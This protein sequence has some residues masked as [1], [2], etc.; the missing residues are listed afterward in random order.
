MTDELD[1]FVEDLQDQIY[2]E[3]REAFGDVVYNRW[4]NP[5]HMGRMDL[6]DGHARVSGSCG[7]TMEIFLRFKDNRVI[8]ASFLTDGCGPSL[9]CASYAAELAMGKSP[10]EVA[11]VSGW[12]I[13]DLL[14]G[15]PEENEHCAFLAAETLH[16]ALSNYTD[17]PR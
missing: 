16:Q 17:R 3:T 12:T 5:R 15:L 8:D 4:R 11:A 2:E 7:D 14:G 1:R 13:L 9:V 10:E 6:P